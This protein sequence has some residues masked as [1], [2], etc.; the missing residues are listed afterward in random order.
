VLRIALCQGDE[1]APN[2]RRTLELVIDDIHWS[3]RQDVLIKP[4]LVLADRPDAITHRDAL[5]ALLDSV[6]ARY[7]GQLTIAEGCALD[8]TMQVFRSLGYPA[9]AD[10]YRAHLLDLNSDE[11]A[12]VTLYH[13]SGRPLHLRLARRV[14]KSDCRISLTLPKTH[15]A[16][17]VTL[18]IKNM[19]M[20]SLVNRRVAARSDRPLWCDRLGR[21]I[22]G[23][24]N[25]WGSDKAAMHQ[26]YPMMNINLALVAQ[27]VRPHLSVLDGHVAMQGAG[28]SDGAL[29]PWG[30]AIASTDPLAVDVLAAR[31]MGF[32]PNE[33][34]YL[35]YCAHLGL[36]C[37]DLAHVEVL[38]NVTMEK[39]A[40]QLIPPQA[41]SG[42]S[43]GIIPMR[44]G[45]SRSPLPRLRHDRSD[46]CQTLASGMHP[47][48]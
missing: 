18:S 41:T 33:I 3:S 9:I 4:N 29:V 7:S 38:G 16:V 46:L 34:G 14:V 2:L 39:A 32:D 15:D 37:A 5:I 17:M 28:P 19:V 23:H 11:I 48:R 43:A 12:P 22:W 45:C 1:R 30:I 6:R 47:M 20:G 36:G 24:G 35:N 13:H 27:L 25:G 10:F 44:P 8:P 26:G 40:R 42:S 21:A 31:L